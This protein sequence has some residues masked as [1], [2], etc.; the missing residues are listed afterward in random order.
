MPRLR[1]T[2]SVPRD[3]NIQNKA[4]WK[5]AFRPL[6]PRPTVSLKLKQIKVVTS[7]TIFIDLKY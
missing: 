4:Q 5:R 1:V 3:L 6:K 7:P 2:K